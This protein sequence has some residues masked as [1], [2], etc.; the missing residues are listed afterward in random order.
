[1]REARPFTPR[2]GLSRSALLAAADARALAETLVPDPARQIVHPR[3]E[4]RGGL[5]SGNLVVLPIGGDFSGG[6]DQLRGDGAL[7]SGRGERRGGGGLRL[8]GG[9]LDVDVKVPVVVALAAVLVPAALAVRAAPRLIA[10]ALG[11]TI[12]AISSALSV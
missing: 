2:P 9:G 3:A 6:G 7:A 4:Q 10:V 1:M 12:P 8:G 11:V 5:L